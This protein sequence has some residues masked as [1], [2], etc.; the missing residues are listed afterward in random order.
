M[1]NKLYDI[2]ISGPM[3]G[4]PEFNYPLFNKTAEVL[5]SYGYVV[6]NPAECFDGNTDLPKEVYMREDIRAV[7]DSKLVVT[8]PFW[9][10]SPG[11]LLEVEV[12]K[13]CGVGVISFE[14]FIKEEALGLGRSNV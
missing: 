7:V 2:Y 11:A 5:R 8:L 9:I 4:Q 3:T 13:A 10:E 1:T 12:A 14:E 6:F